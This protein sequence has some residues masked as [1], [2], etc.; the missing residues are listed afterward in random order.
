MALTEFDQ[1]DRELFANQACVCGHTYIEHLRQP[2]LDEYGFV[3]GQYSQGCHDH[4]CECAAFEPATAPK[5]I[6]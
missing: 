6:S 2:Y 1:Y 4:T 5:E 3:T